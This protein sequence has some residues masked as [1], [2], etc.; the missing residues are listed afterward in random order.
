MPDV[1]PRIIPGVSHLSDLDN[2]GDFG[3][4]IIRF[5]EIAR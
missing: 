3:R 4:V 2:S 5:S 1:R